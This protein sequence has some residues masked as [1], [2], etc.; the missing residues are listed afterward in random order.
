MNVLSLSLQGSIL[1]MLIIAPLGGLY[2][3][4]YGSVLSTD[5]LLLQ[6][7]VLLREEFDLIY[8]PG[9]YQLNQGLYKLLRCVRE[10]VEL[11]CLPSQVPG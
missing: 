4:F 9:V 5:T 11:T 7:A 1:L 8:R 6:S 10:S 3:V 2:S